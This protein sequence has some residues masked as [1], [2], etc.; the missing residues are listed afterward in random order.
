[1]ARRRGSA[2]AKCAER[3]SQSLRVGTNTSA[4]RIRS[5]DALDNDCQSLRS[6][7][8]FSISDETISRR[9][10]SDEIMGLAVSGT[11]SCLLEESKTS[12]SRTPA[13]R[14]AMARELSNLFASAS[15]LL[16]VALAAQT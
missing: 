1:M 9:S 8:S 3:V 12:I 6:T 4:L 15:G 13:T 10:L 16:T 2:A 5:P 7:L 11:Q 14:T